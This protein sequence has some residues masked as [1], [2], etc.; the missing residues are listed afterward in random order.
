M[1]SKSPL[2]SIMKIFVTHRKY[3]VLVY[4]NFKLH[5]NTAEFLFLM[6]FTI[7]CKNERS[8]FIGLGVA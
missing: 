5:L 4:R 7:Y 8:L 1:F 3:L 6:Q 2:S